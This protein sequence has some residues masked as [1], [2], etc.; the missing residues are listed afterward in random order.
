MPVM[1]VRVAPVASWVIVPV[2]L[3]Q[4]MRAVAAASAEAN[5]TLPA[6]SVVMAV[7]YPPCQG[8]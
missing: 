3:I 6:A 5:Q 7:G 4:P 1:V 2:E 8:R